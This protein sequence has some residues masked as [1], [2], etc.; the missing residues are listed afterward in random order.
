[1]NDKPKTM[2]DKKECAAG[3]DRGYRDSVK[4]LPHSGKSFAN[5]Y[6]RKGYDDGYEVDQDARRRWPNEKRV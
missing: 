3:W 1:M 5:P 4:G 2:A 6:F